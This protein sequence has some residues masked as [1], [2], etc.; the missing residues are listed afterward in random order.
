[1]KSA[2]ALVVLVLTAVL[3][4]TGI[5]E[6]AI[7]RVKLSGFENDWLSAFVFGAMIAQEA[8]IS[9]IES[10]KRQVFPSAAPG[11]TRKGTPPGGVSR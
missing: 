4:K 3:L 8:A 10:I 2:F 6:I 9:R 1:M 11:R 7:V 5:F